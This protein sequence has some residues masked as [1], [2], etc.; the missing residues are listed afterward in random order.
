MLVFV[1]LTLGIMA[2]GYLYFQK[3]K[4]HITGD[5]KNDLAAIADLKMS[6]IDTWR[7][8]R[9]AD[10]RMI[11]ENRSA[12]PPCAATDEESARRATGR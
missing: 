10:A 9:L 2:A 11:Y 5:K 1:L 8:E 3:Q 4:D 12:G 6:Q 7:K